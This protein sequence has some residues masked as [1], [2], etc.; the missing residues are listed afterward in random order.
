MSA[1]DDTLSLEDMLAHLRFNCG[2]RGDAER[3]SRC[4]RFP[5]LTAW[6]V[7]NSSSGGVAA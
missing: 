2:L 1:D 3:E 6:F 5:E 4:A 7:E